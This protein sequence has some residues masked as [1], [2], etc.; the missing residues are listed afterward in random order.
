MCSE[1]GGDTDQVWQEY[2]RQLEE[3]SKEIKV[4]GINDYLF[5]DGYKKVLKYKKEGGLKNIEL[6]LPVI[7]FRLKEFVGHE[8]LKR[9]N[10]HII[11]ADE[12]IL[13]SQTIESQFLSG[14]R[15]KASLNPDSP[16][17]ISWGGTVTKETLIELGEKIYNS[18]PEDKRTQKKSYLELGFN[19]INFELSKIEALL[20]ET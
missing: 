17:D 18:I 7:E 16:T 4:I 20:G 2:F 14:F 13:S 15:G 10:Y 1:Y 3:I 6:I 8:K 19:N 12:S 11:F 5:L 9:L